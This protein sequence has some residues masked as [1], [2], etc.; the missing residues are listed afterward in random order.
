MIFLVNLFSNKKNCDILLIRKVMNWVLKDL[1]KITNEKWLNLYEINY[2]TNDKNVK[3]TFASRRS[4]NDL[5]CKLKTDKVD[6]VF[7][8]PRL[9]IKTK[10]YLVFCKEFRPPIND[11]IYSF[12]AGLVENNENPIDAAKRE[13]KEEIGANINN[14]TQI[15]NVCYNSEGL[16]DENTIIFLADISKL[17][18]QNLQDNEDI[19][20]VLVE[21]SKLTSFIQDKK[22][23]VKASLF[24]ALYS[25]LKNL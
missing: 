13:L 15:T 20:I 11:F 10:E 18:K 6:T 2:F 7:I 5:K 19:E 25:N 1:K 22:M 14:F 12:P 4:E 24:C 16:T 8:I 23:N 21:S 3:W 17:K 9:K